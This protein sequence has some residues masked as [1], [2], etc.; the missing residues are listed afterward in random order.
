MAFFTYFLSLS[1]VVL[2]ELET[3]RGDAACHSRVIAAAKA[4]PATT[5]AIAVRKE[6][7][8][9]RKILWGKNDGEQK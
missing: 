6:P 1:L 2:V 4:A 8:G 9:S 5:A 3:G 7:K